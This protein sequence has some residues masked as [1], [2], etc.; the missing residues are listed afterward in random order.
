MTLSH[1]LTKVL[2]F[3]GVFS[4]APRYTESRRAA[5][6]RSRPIRGI[7]RKFQEFGRKISV[8]TLLNVLL[9]FVMKKS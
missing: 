9:L 7:P 8:L 5:S 2:G 1:L 6:R 3:D 4:A